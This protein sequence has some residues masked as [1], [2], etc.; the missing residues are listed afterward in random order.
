MGFQQTSSAHTNPGW[1][2]LEE[3]PASIPQWWFAIVECKNE[4]WNN[5]FEPLLK[6]NADQINENRMTIVWVR[7][8]RLTRQLTMS[9]ACRWGPA[10]SYEPCHIG[11][12]DSPMSWSQTFWHGNLLHE[13]QSDRSGLFSHQIT[14]LHDFIQC[15]SKKSKYWRQIVHFEYVGCESRNQNFCQNVAVSRIALET[16]G[17]AQAPRFL[18]TRLSW[19]IPTGTLHQIFDLDSRAGIRGRCF[20]LY[21]C[22]ILPNDMPYRSVGNAFWSCARQT[23]FRKLSELTMFWKESQTGDEILCFATLIDGNYPFFWLSSLELCHIQSDI[24]HLRT[25]VRKIIK[26][27]NRDNLPPDDKKW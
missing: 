23:P 27:Q 9:K 25:L 18:L 20:E 16:Y 7:K 24:V 3:F 22:Q 26:G 15:S 10:G 21:F 4:C 14:L 2:D 17:S 13:I 11:D 6:N 1:C 12:G 5:I 8:L 19:T